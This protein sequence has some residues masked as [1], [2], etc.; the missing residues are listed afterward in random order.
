[1]AKIVENK[2]GFRVLEVSREELISALSKFG[3]MGI[4]DQCGETPPVGY[5]VAVLNQWLCPKCY[6]N[7]ISKTK[8]YKEDAP[9]EERYWKVALKMF[10]IE[11]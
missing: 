1:M 3:S 10:E 4:C 7:F 6:N 2:K 11:G 8:W 5:Y 9:F